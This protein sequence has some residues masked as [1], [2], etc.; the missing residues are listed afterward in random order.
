MLEVVNQTLKSTLNT[1]KGPILIT[2]HN[3]FMG[4]WLTFFLE[5]LNIEC[6]GI[7]LPAPENSLYNFANREKK[8]QEYFFDLIDHKNTNKIIKK[9]RPSVVIHLAAQPLVLKSYQNIYETFSTNIVATMNIL[10]SSLECDSIKTVLVSTTD[11][12]YE[13]FEKNEAFTESDPLR[14]NDPYSC[15][16]VATESVVAGWQKFVSLSG[17]P[18]ISSIRCGNVIG[19][20]DMAIDRLLPDLIKGFIGNKTIS[21]RNG[22]STRPWQHVLDPLYGFLQVLQKNLEGSLVTAIN[23]GPNSEGLS[24]K[25]VV[26][27]AC[28]YWPQKTS[29]S[30]APEAKKYETNKLNLNSDFAKKYL[31]WRPVFSQEESIE[32]TINWWKRYHLNH[33]LAELICKDQIIN[34]LDQ[35]VY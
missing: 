7:S 35:K 3:G 22:T 31:N 33:E 18:I 24:V 29:V 6:V 14:G 1:L 28:E 12:V 30:F 16:K 13:N 21:I 19:G 34:F 4:T 9:I 26:E 11:K 23:F 20:G 17:G 2:G 15:S 10:Q 32:H 8:I 5:K 25:Q 27:L